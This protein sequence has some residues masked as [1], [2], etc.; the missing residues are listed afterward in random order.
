MITSEPIV[1]P[2]DDSVYLS[3]AAAADLL[4][5]T[6]AEL[7]RR[8]RLGELEAAQVGRQT[9]VRC[10]SLDRCLTPIRLAGGRTFDR[11]RLRNG[12]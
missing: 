7:R 3:L 11:R 4:G 5:I 9:L 1:P 8:I 10:A 6:L 12:V 2:A